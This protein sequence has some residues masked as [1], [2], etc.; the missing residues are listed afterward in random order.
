MR[1]TKFELRNAGIAQHAT[2]TAAAHTSTPRTQMR[3]TVQEL[4]G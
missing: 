3:P 1:L 4:A 2:S